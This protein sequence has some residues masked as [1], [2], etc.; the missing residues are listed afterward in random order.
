MSNDLNH[1]E[2]KDDEIRVISQTQPGAGG[3]GPKPNR[4]A[5]ILLAIGVGLIVIFTVLRFAFSGEKAAQTVVET[6][7]EVEP[8]PIEE[9]APVA[10]PYTTVTDTLVGRV[11]LTILTPH[12][13]TPTLMVGPQTVND[14]AA[15]LIVQAADVRA[16]NGE[17]AGACVVA[18][19][20]MGRGEKKGGYCA[21]IDG[22]MTIGVAESTPLLEE[23][24]DTQGYF[25]RQYPLVVAGQIVENKPKGRALRKALAEL[26]GSIVVIMSRERLTFHEFSQSLVDLGATTAIYLVGSTGYCFYR[27]ESGR[28]FS[29][30]Y[31]NQEVYANLNF[32]VWK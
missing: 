22:K 13:A 10:K 27:T 19:N 7:R 1:N 16:D 11:G 4:K 21:I 23:A 17:I 12:D 20:V 18:G 25:F 6:P 2:I 3:G 8:Q 26:S 9:P 29:S 31:R 30:G 28:A 24:I 5:L 32:L 14:T 15:V